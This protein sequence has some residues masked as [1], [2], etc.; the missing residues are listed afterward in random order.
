[1]LPQTRKA[2]LLLRWSWKPFYSHSSLL[3]GFTCDLE[4]LR[5]TTKTTIKT[6]LQKGLSDRG[7][8]PFGN[9]LPYLSFFNIGIMWNPYLGA[10]SSTGLK[11]IIFYVHAALIWDV[12]FLKGVLCRG[13][14]WNSQG[15]IWLQC[16]D[17]AR[18]SQRGWPE[19]CKGEILQEGPWKPC[20]WSF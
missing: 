9:P 3:K 2:G 15:P 4:H 10:K 16:M 17:R 14:P 6:A 18:Q 12:N 5:K 11:M 13:W 8:F 7:Y 1:M 19:L 20:F